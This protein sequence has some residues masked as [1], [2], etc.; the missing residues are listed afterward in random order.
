[1]AEVKKVETKEENVCSLTQK[2]KDTILKV[3]Q[4]GKEHTRQEMVSLVKE[5]NSDV[6]FSDGI[7]TG[8]IKALT[9][10]G[11]LETVKRGCYKLGKVT[12]LEGDIY[13]RVV[14]VLKRSRDDIEQCCNV[15]LLEVHK[16]E[17]EAVAS[18]VDTRKLL[19]KEI[20]KYTNK[21]IG[22]A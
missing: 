2:A 7:I 8:A 18:I 17:L 19:D 5:R 10:D 15:N 21:G 16:D 20:S 13:K 11:S 22:K 4:D 3:V 12:C 1:M 14:Y 9:V 6:Q